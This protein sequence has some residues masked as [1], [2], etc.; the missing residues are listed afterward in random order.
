MKLGS[1]TI[2]KWLI[3]AWLAYALL[4][5]VVLAIGYGVA[6]LIVH[7]DP[8]TDPVFPPLS[9]RLA[10]CVQFSIPV[11]VASSWDAPCCVRWPQ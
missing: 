4:P 1:L 10:A 6:Y 9:H 11:I 7:H 5:G 3:V 2:R 8:R